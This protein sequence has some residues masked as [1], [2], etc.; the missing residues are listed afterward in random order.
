MMD[1]SRGRFKG[2]SLVRGTPF[3][4]IDVGDR[5]DILV[6]SQICHDAFG[7]VVPRAP[8]TELF[9]NKISLYLQIN[10]HR[11]IVIALQTLKVA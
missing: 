1:G 4:S 11:L 9:I 3:C 5:L 2:V 7:I 8:S 6:R 10:E